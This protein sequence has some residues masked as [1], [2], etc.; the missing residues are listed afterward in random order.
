MAI[1]NSAIGIMAGPSACAFVGEARVLRAKINP[2]LRQSRLTIAFTLKV[3]VAPR[4]EA[5][6]ALRGHVSRSPDHRGHLGNPGST[7]Y[8]NG[9]PLSAK[10]LNCGRKT[11]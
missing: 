11:E 10:R 8:K 5:R 2:P 3:D 9:K 1:F 7:H 4:R 6:S